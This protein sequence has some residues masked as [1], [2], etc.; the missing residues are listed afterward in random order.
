MAL[1]WNEIKSRALTFSKKWAGESREKAEAHSFWDDFFNVFGISRRRVATFEEPAIKLG[2]KPGS[3]DL[4]WKGTLLVEHKSKGKDLDSAYTQAL[5]YF[6]GIQEE[7]LPKYVLVSDF[8]R[9]RL[10]NLDDKT[11]HE[12]HIKEL[13]SHVKLFGFIA[14]Y[15]QKTFKEED[16]VN[17]KAA[18]LMGKLHDQLKV[19]G[20]GGHALEVF[21]VRILFCLFSDDSSIFEKDTF[22]ELIENK[23]KV[24]GSDLGGLLTQLF[25]VLDTPKEK[26]STH[27]DE[28]IAQFPYIDGKLFQETLPIASFNSK[29]REELLRCCYLDWGKISPAVFGSLFQAAMDPDLRRN[30]G[31]HYTS[32]KNILKLIGPLFLDELHTEF[33]KIKGDKKILAEFHKKLARLK[34]LDPACGC[35]NFLVITYRELRRLE[36]EILKDLNKGQQVMDVEHIILLDVD[37]FYGIEIEELP[38][39]IA[40]VALWLTDHQMNMLVHDEFG[41]YLNRLPLKKSAKIVNKNALKT[42][43]NEVV[44]KAEL[45]YILGNPPF[46]GSKYQTDEQ[47]AEMKLVFDGVKGSGELDFVSAWYL[48]AA[49]YIQGTNIKVAFVSTNSI[50]QGA[51]VGVLWDELLNGL[52]IKIHF[53]H[54]TFRWGN[55]ARGRA[56]VYVVIIGFA[57]FDAKEK[58][59]FDYADVDGEPHMK[60]ARNINPYLVE[61]PD[62]ILKERSNPLCKEAPEIGIGNKPIDEGNYLFTEEEK[63]KFLELE[64]KAK[65]LFHPWV[66]AEEFLHGEKRYV[67]WLGEAEPNE[68]R[69]MPYVLER[70]EAVKEYRLKSKSKSTRELAAKPTR[71]H[72][73]NMPTE[74]YLLIPQVT[75]EKRQYIPLGFETPKTICSNLVLISQKATLFDFGILSSKMH[76]SW[77]RQVCGRLESRYRYSKDLVYNN[78]PWPKEPSP[79]NKEKVIECAKKILEVRNQFPGNTLADLYDPLTMPPALTKAHQ[80]LDKA[81]DLCYRPQAFPDETTRIQ[82]LFD[83]Y[84]EYTK[85]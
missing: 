63:T 55:E 24:D 48:I 7:E 40:E 60:K 34:F 82:F 85:K 71:F 13:E 83:L 64:P 15:Q 11:H 56:G 73:E 57:K 10:V 37:Q 38:A 61:G 81:V 26:R 70:I 42:D 6:P 2:G 66:G 25:Q 20:Y 23:T 74:N 39:R 51:Q 79:K 1:S 41:P 18:E 5:D 3:I 47:R 77:V 69:A 43:W 29:M 21:L 46:G 36:L 31:A 19:S 27:L 8:E 72:V 30:L 80:D 22:R 59:I 12:F 75:S 17:I 35:G 14:G 67:L 76:M 32:E 50:T 53:A 16:P 78:Y 65:P 33:T 84:G 68:L 52:G 49:K 9:F 54:K 4:F 28:E 44:P 62:F 58:M 45:S